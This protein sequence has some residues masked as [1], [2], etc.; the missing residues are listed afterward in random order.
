MSCPSQHASCCYSYTRVPHVFSI[1]MHKTWSGTNNSYQHP[2]SSYGSCVNEG[3]S[4]YIRHTWT[5]DTDTLHTPCFTSHMYVSCVCSS[6]RHHV[7]SS[8]L[9]AHQ[10]VFGCRLCQASSDGGG[11][12]TQHTGAK[13][14]YRLSCVMCH[15]SCV[16]VIAPCVMRDVMCGCHWCCIL[17]T[18]CDVFRPSSPLDRQHQPTQ[19]RH[20]LSSSTHR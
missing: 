12:Q 5:Y 11:I 9:Y 7:M 8:Y 17:H 2:H 13:C 20:L 14:M 4:V 1:S 6:C 19:A 18:V 3:T 10:S 16:T 15:V